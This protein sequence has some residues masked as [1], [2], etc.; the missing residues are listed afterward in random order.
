MLTF[1]NLIL[2]LIRDVKQKKK[3]NRF[4]GNGNAALGQL[5]LSLKTV[6]NTSSFSDPNNGFLSFIRMT[7]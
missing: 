1:S 4:R 5:R 6:Q 2:D 3:N 7:P